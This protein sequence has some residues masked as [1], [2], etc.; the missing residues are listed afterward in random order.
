MAESHH[1]KGGAGILAKAQKRLVRTKA[2]VLQNLGKAART[3]DQTFD[4]Y[5]SNFN[6]Q[7]AILTKLQKDLRNYLNCLK[8][9]S[10]A[11]KTLCDTLYEVYEDDWEDQKT[12]HS[13]LES[14]ELHW[15]DYITSLNDHVQEPIIIHLN[16]FP[17]LRMKIN[18]RGRKLVDLD[19]TRHTLENMI[20]QKKR[21]EAK[22]AKAQEEFTEAKKV[23][24]DINNELQVELPEFYDKRVPFYSQSFQ[25][26]FAAEKAFHSEQG[27]ISATLIEICESLSANFIL[28][29]RKSTIRSVSESNHHL[30]NVIDSFQQFQMQS[31]DNGV[32]SLVLKSDSEN[33]TICP[34]QED[35]NEPESELYQNVAISNQEHPNSG[36]SSEPVFQRTSPSLQAAAKPSEDSAGSVSVCEE[37]VSEYQ[38]CLEDSSLYEVPPNNQSLKKLP[39]GILY[40]VQATHPYSQADSDELTFEAGEVIDVIEPDNP[41]EMDDGWLM[42]IKQSD[43]IQGV[44]PANFTKKLLG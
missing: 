33:T 44:F 5:V 3:T 17:E 34:S 32:I 31:K 25:N 16:K 38:S 13:H 10:Y 24:D 14:F 42:G 35:I 36:E 28:P 2:K 19:N 12:F 26:L 11:N 39:D 6:K 29:E 23:F 22:I 8:A 21:D 43:G 20:G 18:K 7:Q 1:S 4:E 40:Q 41:D 27:N 15:M 9:V 37:N 30:Q